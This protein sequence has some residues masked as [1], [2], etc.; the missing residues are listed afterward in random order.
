MKPETKILILALAMVAVSLIAGRCVIDAKG[1]G[2]GI[3]ATGAKVAGS[4]A[5]QM[6]HLN[7][8]AESKQ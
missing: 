8:S 5:E 2:P 1:K 6:S 7:K 4:A 3:G